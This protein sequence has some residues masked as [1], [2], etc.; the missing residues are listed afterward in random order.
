MI[1]S[2]IKQRVEIAL[3]RNAQVGRSANR[4]FCLQESPRVLPALPIG[5]GF[6][7]HI[8]AEKGHVRFT[9][10]S[11]HV[12]RKPSCLLWANSGHR[13]TYS[14]TSSALVSSDGGMVSPSALAV[15]R[16]STDSNFVD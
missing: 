7:R 4:R 1:Q 9:P 10:E 11:G 16:L 6:R 5:V 14:I 13:A 8:C 3:N 15:L 2:S 12:R